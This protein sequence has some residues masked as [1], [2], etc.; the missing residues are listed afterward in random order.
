M[1]FHVGDQ[2]M[3]KVP[4]S[5]KYPLV[6]RVLRVVE[7]KYLI[8][9]LIN[10]NIAPT[11]FE[12]GDDLTLYASATERDHP[13]ALVAQ[14]IGSM[15]VITTQLPVY[16]VFSGQGAAARGAGPDHHMWMCQWDAFQ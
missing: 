15:P 10:L 3:L 1:I 16:S 11:R 6:Y 2:V 4:Q 14:D 8:E 12:S 9:A 5:P 7:G 13:P